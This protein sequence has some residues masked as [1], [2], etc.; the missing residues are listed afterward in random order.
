MGDP[1]CSP[2]SR[3]SLHLSA[4][5]KFPPLPAVSGAAQHSLEVSSVRSISFTHSI[6]CSPPPP[7]LV[8]NPSHSYRRRGSDASWRSPRPSNARACTICA[9]LRGVNPH[10]VLH[11]G[12][13]TLGPSSST[14][15]PAKVG[16]EVPGMLEATARR[17]TPSPPH[18]LPPS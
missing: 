8:A 5:G 18:G 10:M 15:W 7:A 1:S 12:R 16:E 17:S 14:P 4:A 9:L 13:G 3:S 6:R 2:L 11:Q